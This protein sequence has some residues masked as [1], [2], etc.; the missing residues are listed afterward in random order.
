[1]VK[2]D[3]IA[4]E[5]WDDIT[6]LCE[7]AVQGMLDFKLKHVG[8]NCTNPEEA[9]ESAKAFASLFNLPYKAGNSSI[10]AGTAVEFMKSPYLGEHGHIGIGTSDVDRAIYHMSRKGFTFDESTRKTAANGLTKAVYLNDSIA[11]FAIHLV[12]D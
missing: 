4:A 11:G 7:E 5:R 2:K 10:F 9:E 3:L 8:V 6:A 12:K 1:M